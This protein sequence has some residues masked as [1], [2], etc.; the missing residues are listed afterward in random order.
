MN[1]HFSKLIFLAVVVIAAAALLLNQ[2]SN[3]TPTASGLLLTDFAANANSIDR[4]EISN[5]QGMLVDAVLQD[6]QWRLANDQLYPAKQSA[7][8]E[9]VNNLASA[10]RLQAK[11]TKVE[12]YSRLGLQDIAIEDSLATLVTAFSGGKSWGVLVGNAP[13]NGAGQ[14]V[15]IANSKQSWLVDKSVTVPLALKDWQ[16][17]PILP[18][19]MAKLQYV[20]RSG[21]DGWSIFKAD[22][23]QDNYQ[24]NSLPEGR[25]LSYVSVLNGL[26]TAITSMNFEEKF[27]L[28]DEQWSAYQALAEFSL[29]DFD[30]KVIRLQLAQQDEHYFVRFSSNDVQGYWQDWQYQISS[31]SAE[32]LNKSLEEFLKPLAEQESA[33]Q[34]IPS[35]PMDEGESPQ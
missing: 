1:A 33:E 27:P 22:A 2:Q 30:G 28:D 19:T 17:Q 13:A 7:L 18:A 11:T 21:S 24:L 26:V 4:I 35:I 5:A 20:E 23:E 12:Y 25:E 9:L 31:L 8:A 10:K 29:T 6:G 34:S 32:Q 3:T 15:R 16:A 14:Y